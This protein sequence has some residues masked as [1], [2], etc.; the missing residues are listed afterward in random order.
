MRTAAVTLA[1]VCLFGLSGQSN[2]RLAIR[3]TP[4]VDVAPAVLTV[5]TTVERS[6]Q[7]RALEIVVESE[8]YLRSSQFSLDGDRAARTHLLVF[9]DLP[10]GRYEITATLS[11]DHGPL[12]AATRW[13]QAT[14]SGGR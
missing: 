11:G 7:N 10:E 1:C 2:E 5:R 4:P 6:A 13:F 8:N 9:R 14:N 12:A 3:L